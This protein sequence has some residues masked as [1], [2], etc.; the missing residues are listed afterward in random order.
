MV[1]K[2]EN[3]ENTAVTDRGFDLH[4]GMSFSAHD[5]DQ[6]R[7]V[8]G[9][10]AEESGGGGGWWYKK[11]HSINLNG[12]VTTSDRS[13]LLEMRYFDGNEVRMMSTSEMK[14]IRV[15]N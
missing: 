9:N 14:I 10:C 7:W 11:C 2:I 3:G 5:K 13:N 6:D 4:N 12:K 1:A 15:D 8:K